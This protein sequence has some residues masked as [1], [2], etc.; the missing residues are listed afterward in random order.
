MKNINSYKKCSCS[1]SF[2]LFCNFLIFPQLALYSPV[3]AFPKWR[4]NFYFSKVKCLFTSSVWL[5][6]VHDMSQPFP[7]IACFYNH[8]YSCLYAYSYVKH[9]SCQFNCVSVIHAFTVQSR[10]FVSRDLSLVIFHC[11]HAF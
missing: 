1:G 9:Q 6:L 10:S 3:H 2:C 7:D 8:T 4:L 5:K 11:M